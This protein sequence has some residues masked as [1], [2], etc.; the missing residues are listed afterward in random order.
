MMEYGWRRLAYRDGVM[1]HHLRSLRLAGRSGA[2]RRPKR[3][4]MGASEKYII[5]TLFMMDKV[6]A[7]MDD[8]GEL[9]RLLKVRLPKMVDYEETSRLHML[10]E[11]SEEFVLKDGS[12]FVFS[13]RGWVHTKPAK[14]QHGMKTKSSCP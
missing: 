11:L 10:G 4:K 12:R 5:V 13:D 14:P 8:P 6:D 7:W 2:K 3:G 9:A 1:D